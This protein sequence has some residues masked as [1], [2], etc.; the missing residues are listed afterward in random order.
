MMCAMFIILVVFASVKM[1]FYSVPLALFS[2]ASGLIGTE[3]TGSSS[4]EQ[5][6]AVFI[7][8]I[9]VLQRDDLR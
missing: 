8:F 7:D 9:A 3:Y 5:E 2:R 6:Q 4:A 1:A